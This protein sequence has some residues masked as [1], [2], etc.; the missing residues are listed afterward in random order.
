MYFQFCINTADM[1]NIKSLGPI[2]WG[3]IVFVVH[4]LFSS[5]R[6][7]NFCR[8][9]LRSVE[10]SSD[11]FRSVQISSDQLRSVGRVGNFRDHF[12]AASDLI[13]AASVEL[14][15]I[16]VMTQSEGPV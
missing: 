15:I 7:L 2:I 5:H 3:C 1:I 12:L 6:F 9:Q 10:I 4:T 8:D 16:L 13:S 14:K 11:Q